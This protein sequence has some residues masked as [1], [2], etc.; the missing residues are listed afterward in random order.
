MC[1]DLS[2]RACMYVCECVCIC[3][4]IC[5]Y[6]NIYIIYI[7]VE[8]PLFKNLDF[9]MLQILKLFECQHEISDGKLRAM[10]LCFIHKFL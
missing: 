8:H 7:Q 9:E 5:I 6:I 2:A 3:V 1:M 4:Y 10:K